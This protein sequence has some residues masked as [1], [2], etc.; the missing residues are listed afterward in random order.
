MRRRDFIAG[1][2]SAAAIPSV[3]RAQQ[4]KVPV[5]GFIG[6]SSPDPY[7]YL[8]RAFHQGLGEIGYVEGRDL[9]IEYRWAEGQNDRLPALAAD[10]VSRNVSAIFVTGGV[11]GALAAK[12][13]TKT[14]PIVFSNSAD[15]VEIG[16]V[17]ALNRPGGNLTGVANLNMELGS[18]RL[19]L[20]HE[21]VTPGK[22][23]GLLINPTNPVVTDAVLRQSQAAA[24]SLGVQLSVLRASTERDFDTVFESLVRLQAGGL[25]IT[26]DAFFTSR[27][28]QLATLALRNAVPAI[29][30]YREFPAA[31]GL[32]S[33]GGDPT[34]GF[35]IAGNYVGRILRGD[36]PTDLPVQR[37]TK[38]E[39]I[40]NMK[41]A[42]AL[43]LT[44]PQT[45]LARADEVIE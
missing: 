39:L 40:I 14:I 8:V 2:G 27:S 5:I 42:K 38:V 4:P 26:N 15:P 32:M 7:A 22:V 24:G 35:R 37:L 23:I 19:E 6:S 12:A 3:A 10:L 34:D 25:V 11:P 28:K 18:K 36:K 16:L 30:Q 1:L 17:A 44:F 9:T 29:Y 45:L 13:A 33:Y 41:T 20:L 43:G 31:G 21:V